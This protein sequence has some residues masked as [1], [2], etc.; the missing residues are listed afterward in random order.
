MKSKKILLFILFIIIFITLG[1]K[2]F[3]SWY[4]DAFYDEDKDSYYEIYI[5]QSIG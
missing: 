3:A 4:P 5:G 1:T 2:S